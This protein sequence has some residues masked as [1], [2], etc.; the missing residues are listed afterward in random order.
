MSDFFAPRQESQREEGC[1]SLGALHHVEE[2]RISSEPNCLILD[3]HRSHICEIFE[4]RV[5][6]TIQR[7][8]ACFTLDARTD[9]LIPARTR[10]SSARE[11]LRTAPAASGS[12]WTTQDA[13][14][15]ERP[16]IHHAYQCPSL[17]FHGR[18]GSPTRENSQAPDAVFGELSTGPISFHSDRH[19]SPWQSPRSVATCKLAPP[20]PAIA[21]AITEPSSR[22]AIEPV[23]PPRLVGPTSFQCTR[24]L[25]AKC[26]HLQ[27]G[28]T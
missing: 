24:S 10:A 8:V 2:S 6:S 7:T 28:N 3:D 16:A 12:Q 15:L 22:T 25:E 23:P 9:K 27:H 4:P 1:V 11:I 5:T 26:S 20:P 17:A 21:I 19:L 13:C 14:R 18:A